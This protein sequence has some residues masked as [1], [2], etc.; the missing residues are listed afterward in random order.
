MSLMPPKTRPALWTTPEHFA[1]LEALAQAHCYWDAFDATEL[2]RIGRRRDRGAPPLDGIAVTRILG[3]YRAVRSVDEDRDRL[4][5]VV[6]QY[7]VEF[8]MASF[9]RRVDIVLRMPDMIGSEKAPRSA[10]TKLFWFVAPA[11]WIMCDSL[12][13]RAL[14]IWGT[15]GAAFRRFYNRLAERQ[16]LT[17]TA[18]ARAVLGRHDL[19]ENLAERSI[20][21]LLMTAGGRKNPSDGRDWVDA[22]LATRQ[23]NVAHALTA[24]AAELASPY[25]DFLQ[26]VKTR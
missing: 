9:E 11:D 10:L 18:Q 12:G 21:F 1:A 3:L 23:P 16:F 22:Y 14:R 17:L 7:A 25:S 6:N 20:D 26:R 13:R 19:P 5:S 24:A 4:A 8:E 2:A 15:D